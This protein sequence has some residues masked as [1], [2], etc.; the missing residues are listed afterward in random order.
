MTRPFGEDGDSFKFSMFLVLCN[1]LVTC[2]LAVCCLLVS[3]YPSAAL[4]SCCTNQL[5]CC[6][7]AELLHISIYLT[8][9]A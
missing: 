2:V 8:L 9:H 4:D 6:C 1:R 3:C 7:H 5:C